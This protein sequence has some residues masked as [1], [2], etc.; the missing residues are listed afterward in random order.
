[1]QFVSNIRAIRRNS[2]VQRAAVITLVGMLAGSQ[3]QAATT[4]TL[5]LQDGGTTW[6][7]S[8]WIGGMLIAPTNNPGDIVNFSA[9]SGSGSR[10]LDTN[11]TIG[12]M[13]GNVNAN[14]ELTPHENNY[15]LTFDN[16][17]GDVNP[18]GNLR[19]F[20]GTFGTGSIKLGVNVVLNGDLDIAT[21]TGTIEMTNTASITGTGNIYIN[22]PGSN[23]ITLNNVQ[24]AGAVVYTGSQ[25]GL[26]LLNGVMGPNATTFTVKSGTVRGGVTNGQFGSA[27]IILGDTSG[28]ADVTFSARGDNP[29][30]ILVVGGNTGITK[31]MGVYGLGNGTYSGTITL[32]NHDLVLDFAHISG[33]VVGTGDILFTNRN[34]SVGATSLFNHAGAITLNSDQSGT[35][36]FAGN[37]GANVTKIVQ[38]SPTF[39]FNLAGNNSSFAG[40]VFVKAGTLQA[41][42]N[43]AL[44]ANN[45]VHVNSDA[46]FHVSNHVTIAG[47]VDGES[48]GG[49]VTGTG[50][51]LTLAGSGTY[52][53]S[54]SRNA[55]GP[56]VKDGT[57]TQI[58]TGDHVYTGATSINGG[59]LIIDGSLGETVVTVNASGTLGGSGTIGGATTIKSGGIL[60]P[61]SSPGTLTFLNNLTLN[62]GAILQFEAGDLVVVNGTL[63][64]D[65]NWT[66]ALGG[67]FK[68]GGSVVLFDYTTL[69]ANPDFD[70]NFDLSGLGF[71]PTTPL[72]LVDTGSQIVLNG[73][74]VAVP[75]P[76]GLALLACGAGLM[77]R[78]RRQPVNV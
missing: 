72:S 3:A 66:L 22:K 11:V 33:S 9:I 43:T 32:D 1:M 38:E 69:A 34:I 19:S 23:T 16:T 6:T 67:G 48:G 29:N 70:P 37:I 76:A 54:G 44:N 40:P 13:Q 68:N 63:D 24:N 58:F 65:D 5:M 75:E 78:R 27:Q 12:Q 36:G 21:A 8:L 14:F 28:D 55:T 7:D 39:A 52:V 20:L 77:I 42:S 18:Q 57:G 64:L 25:S 26:L 53:F 51:T 41:S 45:V 46:T 59:A 73:I 30:N 71:V 60:S 35:L 10:Q 49:S 4:H 74:S 56:L 47:L 2:V 17:G 31:L 61:G 50:H 15:T 62:N